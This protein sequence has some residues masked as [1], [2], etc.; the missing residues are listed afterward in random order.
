MTPGAI[1]TEIAV[2]SGPWGLI[3][4][5]GGLQISK[6]PSGRMLVTLAYGGVCIVAQLIEIHA[7]RIEVEQVI[8]RDAEIHEP[9]GV[10]AIPWGRTE[11]QDL[12]DRCAD[13]LECGRMTEAL[14]HRLAL[15]IRKDNK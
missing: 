2:P 1:Q 14:A 8:V 10:L 5:G 3:A 15:E 4:Q 13:A 6:A 12:Y 9:A 11:H 7:L